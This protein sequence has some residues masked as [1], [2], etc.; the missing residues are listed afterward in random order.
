MFTKTFMNDCLE[1]ALSTFAQSFVA[2]VGTDGVGILD[3]GVVDSLIASLAAG[4]LA[5]LKAVANAKR[6]STHP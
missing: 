3:V 5:V 1:R 6:A 4:L 2:L